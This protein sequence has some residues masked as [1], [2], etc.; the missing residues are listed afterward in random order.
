MKSK[1][2]AGQPSLA[3]EEAESAQGGAPLAELLGVSKKYGE[4]NALR[5]VSLEFTA[6]RIHGLVGENGAGKSTLVKILSGLV[7][8]DSGQLSVDGKVL[9]FDTP[10][11]ALDRGISTVYQE[12]S[13]APKL[14]VAENLLMGWQAKG[15]RQWY[16]SHRILDATAEAIMAEW[17]LEGISPFSLVG[18]LSLGSQQQLEI[19]RGCARRPRLLILDE[20][21]AALG[22]P[23]VE[24][25][26]SQMRKL[27]DAGACI[28]YI[29][30]RLN[31]V[32]LS[33]T[34]I[35][36]L[37]DGKCVA[38]F[39]T[40]RDVP[41]RDVV[42]AI[43]GRTIV[44]LERSRESAPRQGASVAI[45][46]ESMSVG[47]Q[48]KDVS[49]QLREGEILGV[50]AL[51]GSGQRE[52]FLALF[53]ALGV[54]SGAL[55]V[56]GRR[57]QFSSPRDA[58]KAGI[59]LVP[60]DRKAGGLLL[61]SSLVSNV[62]LASLSKWQ[63]FG[64]VRGRPARC[65]TVN[66]L[67]SL[68][69]SYA[70]SNDRAGGLSGGNQQKVVLAKWLA[71]D[72]KMFLMYDPTRGVDP[73]TKLDMYAQLRRLVREG[74]SVMLYSTELDEILN[75]S[76]RII[77]LYRGRLVVEFNELP[78]KEEEVVSAMMGIAR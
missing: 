14:T 45:E 37:R 33:C 23:A 78:V 3:V 24:W 39:E 7:K 52:L 28:V 66:L 77:V 64:F 21:T 22:A 25:L 29:S 31:E 30:H 41:E 13:L 18:R 1:L 57:V 62:A 60:E 20:P 6:G 12:L 36:V 65:V 5:D 68:A 34:D 53:G 75:L 47:S 76:D 43:A 2:S 73:A 74:R 51:E 38:V 8:P 15:Q 71:A 19:V 55:K 42:R 27:R 67:D 54:N 35:T 58:V 26:F 9:T 10:R 50:A 48:V 17:S 61:D 46:A 32:R 44:A 59:A 16:R 49:F 11:D 69:V 72:S 56:G 40:P 63:R 4:T 70:S